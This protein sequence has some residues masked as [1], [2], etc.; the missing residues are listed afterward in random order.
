M[1]EQ[2]QNT[3]DE[4]E[5]K[6]RPNK[7]GDSWNGVQGRRQ[8]GVVMGDRAVEMSTKASRRCEWREPR[9]RA[10]SAGILL[11]RNKGDKA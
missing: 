3:R 1:V 10:R 8:I 6:G 7:T 9:N 5:G 2:D 4:E 11:A